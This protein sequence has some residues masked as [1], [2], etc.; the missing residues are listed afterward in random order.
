MYCSKCGTLLSENDMYCSK[1]GTSVQL[2]QGYG[3]PQQ[4]YQQTQ[5]PQQQIY[6]PQQQPQQETY[7][8]QQ[9]PNQPQQQNYRQ[10]Q[11]QPGQ[12]AAIAA[13]VCGLVGI[14]FFGI[15]LGV[16]AIVQGNKAK[17]LGNT[18]GMAQAGFVLGIIDVVG[19]FIFILAILV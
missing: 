6:Q 19:W 4:P 2:Q 1:C 11:E 9:Q 13:L 3:Q 17:N 7:Q 16:I 15:I 8:H 18:S 12:G 14:L 5:E 10:P